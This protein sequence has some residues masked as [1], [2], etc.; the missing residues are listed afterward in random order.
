MLL[1]STDLKLEPVNFERYLDSTSGFTDVDYR[2]FVLEMK[3]DNVKYYKSYYD[4]VNSF[5][6]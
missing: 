2:N 6:Y 5:Y 3:N 4:N 1:K